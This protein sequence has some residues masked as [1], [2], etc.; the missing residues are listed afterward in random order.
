MVCLCKHPVQSPKKVMSTSPFTAN[1]S[2]VANI[3]SVLCTAVSL[4]GRI[5]YSSHRH[6]WRFSGDFQLSDAQERI[7]K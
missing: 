6:L 4:A 3:A 7:L 1:G 5:V 2:T